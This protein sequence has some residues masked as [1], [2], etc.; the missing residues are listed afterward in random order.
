MANTGDEILRSTLDT[1]HQQ[2]L[3]RCLKFS[4]AIPPFLLL[5][6]RL[7]FCINL[8]V[9]Q[10]T[11]SHKPFQKQQM[12]SALNTALWRKQVQSYLMHIGLVEKKLRYPV[13]SSLSKIL[14]TIKC[15]SLHSMYTCFDFEKR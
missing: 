12:P 4:L 8:H 5:I 11:N 9:H 2:N 14:W 6:Q 10:S 13:K 3:E 15:C 1:Q 7:F